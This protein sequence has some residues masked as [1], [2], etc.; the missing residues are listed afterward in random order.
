MD[1]FESGNDNFL[2][3]EGPHKISLEKETRA[4]S[5]IQQ[6]AKYYAFQCT[7]GRERSENY[8]S[9]ETFGYCEKNSKGYAE[10]VTVKSGKSEQKLTSG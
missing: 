8:S 10:T 5:R 2:C 1:S 4:K 3:Q 9:D 6:T 7:D